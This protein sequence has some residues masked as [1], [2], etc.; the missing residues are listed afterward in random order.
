MAWTPNFRK[1][2]DIPVFDWLSFFIGGNSQHGTG[3][4]YDGVRYIYW[5][6]QF[7]T[8]SGLGTGS[9]AQLWRYDTWSDGWQFLGGLANGNAGMDVEYDVAR[10]LVYILNGNSATTMQ[11]F[12]CNLVPVTVF[13]QVMAAFTITTVTLALPAAAATGASLTMTDDFSSNAPLVNGVQTIG[14]NPLPID[15]GIIGA[16][17]TTTNITDTSSN[18]GSFGPGNVGLHVR[19]T[20]GTLSGQTAVITA[21]PSPTTL[22]VAAF[23]SAP[24]IGDA[25]VVEVPQA[26]STGA[27]T[28]TTLNDTS[29]QRPWVVNQYANSDVLITSG[30]GAGQRRRIAS[31]TATTLTLAAAVTGNTRTGPWTTTPDATSVYRI[32]PSSDFLYFQPGNNTTT[33]Y[34][35]DVVAT[36]GTAWSAALAATPAGISG[37]GNTMYP[38]AYSPFQIL[39]FRGNGGNQVYAYNLGLNTWVTLTTFFAGETFTTGASAAMLHGHRRMWIAKDSSQRAYTLDLTTGILE[40]GPFVPYAA[41]GGVDG[42]RS[43]YVKTADGVEWLY[44]LRASGQEFFRVP[45]EWL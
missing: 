41:P 9:T 37:G 42:H 31:N 39:C 32:V 34:R 15:T 17:A 36:T 33:F 8:S 21:V 30:L 1:A 2:V 44:H 12:N 11:I 22:T 3:N 25:Y 43:R 24:A 7:G 26:L 29:A 16:G 18:P 28:T 20:S 35:V 13:N 14:T 4:A 23:G 19:F 45:L 27:N 6:I 10:G 40:P 5:A 38:Q